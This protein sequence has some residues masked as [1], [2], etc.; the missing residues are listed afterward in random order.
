MR[1]RLIVKRAFTLVELLAVIAIIALLLAILLP[2]A[3]SAREAARRVQCANNVKQVAIAV[4]NYNEQHQALPFASGYRGNWQPIR[5]PTWAASV[6][7]F[8]EQQQHYDLFDFS[9]AMDHAK[10][11]VAVTTPVAVYIC[12]S[13]G[14]VSTGVMNDRCMCCGQSVPVRSAGLWYMASAGT[15]PARADKI[16]PYCPNPTSSITNSCC[17]GEPYGTTGVPPGMFSRSPRSVSSAMV[18][19]GMSN[20]IMLGEALPSV[21]MHNTAFCANAPIGFTNIPMN[22]PIPISKR[23]VPGASDLANHTNNPAEDV[24]GYASR[25]LGGAT[26]AMGDG[27]VHFMFDS[28]DFPLYNALGTRDGG[29][30]VSFP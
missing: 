23:I 30:A 17:Q 22:L 6:L 5:L 1:Q 28:I 8:V 10:N 15:A 29:E 24:S 27:S 3:Q 2:A 13:D 14:S 12:P 4:L 25:H 16:C 20:T 19:D 9:Q 7:P 21:N 26:F 18:R 11:A